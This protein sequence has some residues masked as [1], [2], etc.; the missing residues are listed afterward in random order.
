MKIVIFINAFQALL[1]NLYSLTIHTPTS[2][3]ILLKYALEIMQTLHSDATQDYYYV[4][5]L[6]IELKRNTA[7]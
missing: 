4:N 2:V 5:G 6:R 3:I 7:M 1:L